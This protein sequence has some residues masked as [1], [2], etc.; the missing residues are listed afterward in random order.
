M[1]ASAFLL[2]VLVTGLLSATAGAQWIVDEWSTGGSFA[3]GLDY[4]AGTGTIW[5]ADPTDDMIRQFNRSGTLLQSFP[6]PRANAVGVG[7][8]SSTGNLWIGDESETVDEV[9]SAGVPTGRSWT[10]IPHVTDLSGVTFD[11]LGGHIYVSQDSYPQQI[12]EFDQSG[13]WI[14]T[15][16][17]TGTGSIDPD[18]LVYNSVTSTFLLG[19]E[20]NEEVIEVDGNGALLDSWDM[21]ALRIRPEGMGLDNQAGTVF[22]C[23]GFRAMVFEV[24]GIIISGPPFFTLTVDPDPLQGWQTANF[25]ITHGDPNTNTWLA[26][27]LTGPGSMWVPQLDVTLGLANAWQGAGPKMTDSAGSL[28]WVLPVPNAPGVDVWLQGIQYRRVTN[29]VATSIQ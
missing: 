21:R 4:D 28:T 20:T 15:I 2:S 17:V 19:D 16:D 26:C 6:A 18:G 10:T 12:V 23:D 5:V 29:V 3:G 24:G 22:I 8:D 14:R 25:V 9:T 27:S 13:T 1:R 11:P 7:A